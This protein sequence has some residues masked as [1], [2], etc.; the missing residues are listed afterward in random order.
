LKNFTPEKDRDFE[1]GGEHFR[2]KNPHWEDTAAMYDED[3]ARVAA[4]NGQGD[5]E[6]LKD[7]I[8]RTLKRIELFIEDNPPG[9]I[10]RFR[11]LTKR[12]E[13][14]VPIHA[15]GDLYQWLLEVSSERPTEPLSVSPAGDGSDE[16]TSSEESS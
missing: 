5:T 14:A 7:S 9:S 6:S 8:V 10:D 16:A 2:W 3:Q 15:W 4:S 13:Q 1:I 11:K 12:K